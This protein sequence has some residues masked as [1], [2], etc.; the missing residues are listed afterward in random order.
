MGFS[1]SALQ[2]QAL[3]AAL[4]L[5]YA[6]V[7]VHRFPDG[8][9]RVCVPQPAAGH[10]L[11]FRSLDHPNDKLVELLLAAQTLRQGGARRLTLVAPYLCY[12]R[13]DIAF[14]PGEAVSQRIVGGFLAGLFD[15]VVTVDPHLHRVSRLEEAVPAGNA[16][17]LTAAPLFGDYLAAERDALLIGPDEESA[18]WVGAMA[19]ASGLEH[20]IASKQRNGDRD[21]VIQLPEAALAG[22][23][24][25][26]ADD[27]A[28][29]GHTLAAIARQLIAAGVSEV[30]A[31]I[32]H[33]LFVGDALEVLRSA[34]V[35]RIGSSDSIPHPSNVVQL[36]PL[37]AD[38]VRRLP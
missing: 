34:G 19:A 13:Q 11:L 7:A 35:S 5:P 3:A 30:D 15:D 24:V 28:S 17:C 38:A 9:S 16:V 27:M 18:Q 21:V 6:Q 37:L 25:V 1:E 33:A 32:T 31:L 36:A 12:M 8:E 10:V 23:K 29:T 22:R 2:A 14:H 20:V 26:L 4:D